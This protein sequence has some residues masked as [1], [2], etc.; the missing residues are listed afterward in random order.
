MQ[1]HDTPLLVASQRH[2]VM[3][4]DGSTIGLH[5][6]IQHGQP[7]VMLRAVPFGGL[8]MV[9]DMGKLSRQLDADLRSS[10]ARDAH[11]LIF[12][13]LR[14]IYSTASEAMAAITKCARPLMADQ[15][16]ELR[17]AA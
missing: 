5:T 10:H 15:A 11:G 2:E 4:K 7:S 1:A 17:R 13:T 8:H 3:F 9:V 16:P 14:Q 6:V 12:Y